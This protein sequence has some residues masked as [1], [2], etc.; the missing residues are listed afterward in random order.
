LAQE[1][2]HRGPLQPVAAQ[3][4]QINWQ[5]ERVSTKPVHLP[6]YKQRADSSLVPVTDYGAWQCPSLK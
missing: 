5:R 3:R 2:H 1:P 6:F 4:S